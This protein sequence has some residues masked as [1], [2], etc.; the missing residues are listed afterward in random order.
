MSSRDAY[1]VYFLDM[2]RYTYGDC[3]LIDHPDAR[4]LI[5]GGYA[6]LARGGPGSP[7]IPSQL[8]AILRQDPPFEL[9]LLVVTHCHLDH[10]GCLPALVKDGVIRADWALVADPDLG[11]GPTADH[12]RDR[13]DEVSP[14]VAALAAALR[15]EPHAELPDDLL[16]ELLTDAPRLA[17][18]YRGMLEALRTAGTRVIRYGVDAH[19][20][21]EEA[22]TSLGLEVLGPTPEHLAICARRIREMERDALRVA[23]PLL[24]GVDSPRGLAAVYRAL[25]QPL[26]SDVTGGSDRLGKGAALNDQSIV[27]SIASGG[28]KALL[29]GD[30]QLAAAEV[31]GLEPH[32]AS[33]LQRIVEAGPYDL[34]KVTHH[35]SYNGLDEDVLAALPAPLLVHSGGRGSSV[36]PHPDVLQLLRQHAD[37]L[38]WL[39]TDRNGRIG[40]RLGEGAPRVFPCEGDVNDFSAADQD[41]REGSPAPGASATLRTPTAT[42]TT[43]RPNFPFQPP[44][45]AQA[46][47]RGNDVEVI[48]RL[49]HERTRVTL[50][51]T[52]EPDAIDG[53]GAT[54][55]SQTLGAATAL[56][57]TTDGLRLAAGR[58]LPPLLFLT[59]DKGLEPAVGSEAAR[60]AVAMAR[61]AGHVVYT[62]LSPEREAAPANV[63]LARKA[64]VEA[65]AANEELAGV[66]ILGNYN[67]VPSLALDVLDPELRTEVGGATWDDDLMLVWSDDPY[68]DLD[69]DGFPELPVSRIPD[70]GSGRFF[71]Q[72]LTVPGPTEPADRFGVRNCRRPFAEDIYAELPGQTA[73]AV[74]APH[75]HY[76]L[77]ARLEPTRYAYFMLHGN[78]LDATTF[79]GEWD[80]DDQTSDNPAAFS[81]ENVPTTFHGVAF[82]GCCWG[83]LPVDRPAAWVE[84]GRALHGRNA[85]S[86]IA[87]RFLRAGAQAFVGCTGSHYSP[88][89]LPYTYFGAPFHL[90]F[91]SMVTRGI[92]PA[93]ALLEAKHHYGASM[94]HVTGDPRYI[95][96]ELKIQQQ[97]TCLGL[98]W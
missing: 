38:V 46:G 58:A 22:F 61:N 25:V 62:D 91:W 95:A 8:A 27:L 54:V 50:S 56:G 15:E 72:C 5:D 75:L 74:S 40:V 68:G 23:S 69:G 82:S 7:S 19:A 29:A 83:A 85:E 77:P 84:P 64:L 16:L 96:I 41:T 4:I 12:E 37:E 94:P 10:I 98:G 45:T 81:L 78:A 13:S 59:S 86:S 79:W 14:S 36:H 2:G 53:S 31:P 71:L 80:D 21:L 6:G 48:L 49:P 90:A 89:E 87:M 28:A 33:L 42:V 34:V 97:F 93:R 3:L 66:V 17:P 35:S 60:R 67:V 18:R 26:V 70:G 47:P 1:W 52:V 51:V 88:R 20:P 73:L 39:R 43:A 65:R 24:T 57:S 44:P 76:S 30:V 32:M 63:E 92:P 11:F 55:A 9:S